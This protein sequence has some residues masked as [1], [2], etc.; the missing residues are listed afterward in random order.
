MH[1]LSHMAV[2]LPVERPG[3][4]CSQALAACFL[5]TEFVNTHVTCDVREEEICRGPVL[6]LQ[7]IMNCSHPCTLHEMCVEMLFHTSFIK[8][9]IY[10]TI[11]LNYSEFE[12]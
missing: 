11:I 10:C 8:T 3:V 1:I 2:K 4:G 12:C 5:P 7:C 9:A 6:L